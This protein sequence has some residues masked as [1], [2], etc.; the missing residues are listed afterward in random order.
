MSKST[1][2]NSR[3]THIQIK[4]AC[5][6]VGRSEQREIRQYVDE[7]TGVI[8]HVLE[9]PIEKPWRGVPVGFED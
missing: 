5:D 4:K 3:M 8:V 9:G 2:K 7:K 6:E 1:D